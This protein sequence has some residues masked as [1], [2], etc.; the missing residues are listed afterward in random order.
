[1]IKKNIVEAPP[2]GLGGPRWI[3]TLNN[4]I[5]IVGRPSWMSS[6]PNIALPYAG[7]T[8]WQRLH[9]RLKENAHEK[10]IGLTLYV[11]PY[12][13]FEAPK[14][15]SGYGYFESVVVAQRTKKSVRS[16]VEALN[17]CFPE[18]NKIKVVKVYANGT[19]E[20]WVRSSW[21]PCMI[22]EQ[23][24]E[25]AIKDEGIKEYEK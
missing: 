22:G 11:P 12:G 5:Y 2:D 16:G 20:H 10:I 19:L 25:E 14:N 6:G 3:A 8:D 1:M 15:L 17:I 21:L 24:N 13:R 7:D 23:I 4:G 9:S 18:K